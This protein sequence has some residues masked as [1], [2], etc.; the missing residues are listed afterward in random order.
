MADLPFS[1]LRDA[2]E[3]LGIHRLTAARAMGL[4]PAQ[5]NRIESGRFRPKRETCEAI[6][7]FYGGLL[8]R[9]MIYDPTLPAYK[10]ALTAELK[11]Q[12]KAYYEANHAEKFADR[13][14]S[15]A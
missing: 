5:Y 7:R 11:R 10:R 2:R 3:A 15:N 4:D 9:G 1:V 13:R 14:A 12:I 6:Y 8:E